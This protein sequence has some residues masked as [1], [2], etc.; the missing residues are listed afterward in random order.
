MANE[1]MQPPLKTYS[2]GMAPAGR[3]D[4]PDT[5]PTRV[6]KALLKA[7]GFKAEDVLAYNAATKTV[8]TTG[9]SKYRL[10]ANGES[11]HHLSGP[12]A[13]K[14]TGQ[15]DVEAEARRETAENR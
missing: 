6:S 10:D 15:V 7:T 14:L 3:N 1:N 11:A 5:D 9:G 4:E 2:T 12:I 8:V 13:P